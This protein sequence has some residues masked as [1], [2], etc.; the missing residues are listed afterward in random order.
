MKINY[1]GLAKEIAKREGKNKSMSIAQ[2]KEVLSIISDIFFEY[3]A[4]CFQVLYNNGKRRN[5]R[6]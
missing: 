4:R 3:G 5:K 2:I 6:K 1:T